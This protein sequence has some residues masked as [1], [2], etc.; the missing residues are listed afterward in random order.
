MPKEKY[1][2]IPHFL[3]AGFKQKSAYSGINPN[4]PAYMHRYMQLFIKG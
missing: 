4:S 3:C 1:P 2:E